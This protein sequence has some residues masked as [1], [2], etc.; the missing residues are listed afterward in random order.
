ML[1][2]Q[3][4]ESVVGNWF[5]GNTA[6]TY[7]EEAPTKRGATPSAVEWL[8]L[9]CVSGKC[10]NSHFPN[11]TNFYGT[12]GVRTNLERSEAVVGHWTARVRQWHVECDRF[13][14]KLIIRGHGCSTGCVIFSSMYYVYSMVNLARRYIVSS[15]HA[16]SLGPKRNVTQPAGCRFATREMGHMG[17]HADIWGTVQC[18]Q[19]IQFAKVGVHLFG[20]SSFGA[21][22]GIS[23]ADGHGYYQVFLLIRAGIVRLQQW[24]ESIVVVSL[25]VVSCCCCV[26]ITVI[27]QFLRYYADL[28]KKKCPESSGYSPSANASADHNAC[29]VWRRFAKLVKKLRNNVYIYYL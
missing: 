18:G 15:M 20:E 27:R 17:S 1:A 21:V 4:I 10:F 5:M 28:E 8:I 19:H 13:C 16:V 29:I 14:N 25:E 22:A 24:S 7:Q 12:F 9:S 6:T 26:L 3:R 23:F 2:S 11:L